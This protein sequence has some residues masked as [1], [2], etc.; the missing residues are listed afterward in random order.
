M[1]NGLPGEGIMAKNLVQ[2]LGNKTTGYHWHI[3]RLLFLLRK[4]FNRM[5]AFFF[6]KRLLVI[7]SNYPNKFFFSF[8][9]KKHHN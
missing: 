8:F 5:K 9:A 6:Q 1:M 4:P 7:F 2:S 3:F